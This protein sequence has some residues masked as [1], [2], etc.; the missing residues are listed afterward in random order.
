[1]KEFR[2]SQL[3]ERTLSGLYRAI[4]DGPLLVNE[5][6]SHLNIKSLSPDADT[7]ESFMKLFFTY[8]NPSPGDM[9]AMDFMLK[10]LNGI[11][12]TLTCEFISTQP[13]IPDLPEALETRRGRTIESEEHIGMKRWVRKHLSSKNIQ[14]A[15]DEVSILGYEVDVGS[16]SENVFVECGDTEPSK[17]FEFLRNGHIIGI[18]Q[19]DAEEI[20]WFRPSNAFIR[21][22]RPEN[23]L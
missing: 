2:H 5:I 17:V 12:I 18:L 20:V 23:F 16:L 4:S 9:N 22:A 10:F 11:D 8:R 13:D 6:I 7:L 3:N 15:S 1:M 21:A 14:V 19:Y